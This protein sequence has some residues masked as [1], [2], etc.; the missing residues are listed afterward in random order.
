MLA[1]TSYDAYSRLGW[2]VALLHLGRLLRECVVDTNLLDEAYGV[3]LQEL[4]LRP[5][6]LF[7]HVDLHHPSG[8]TLTTRR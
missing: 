3:L 5:A 6:E 1:R 7:A 4:T 2:L 8:S